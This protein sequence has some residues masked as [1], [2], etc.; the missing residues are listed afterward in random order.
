MVESTAHF[1]IFQLT[2]HQH[3]ILQTYV[4]IPGPCHDVVIAAGAT[5]VPYKYVL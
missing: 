4:I 2:S 1:Y 5:S 3:V